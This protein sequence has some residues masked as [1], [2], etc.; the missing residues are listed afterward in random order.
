MTVATIIVL[1]SA[2]CLAAEPSTV[3]DTL[4]PGTRAA[5]IQ[6]MQGIDAAMDRIHTALVTGDH[7]TVSAE[8]KAIRDSFILAQVLSDEQRTEIAALPQDFL[9]A[10]RAF[11]QVA[12]RLVQAG[13]THDSQAERVWYDEMTRACLA[14]HEAFAAGRFPGLTAEAAEDDHA[15]H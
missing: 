14:C 3:T 11:H 6:E 4:T 9:G 1:S 8:A 12:E 2:A 5:L 7:A 15:S 10:D 13:E